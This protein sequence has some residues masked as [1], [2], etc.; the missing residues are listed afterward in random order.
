MQADSDDDAITANPTWSRR[1]PKAKAKVASAIKELLSKRPRK[2]TP[3]NV[4][5]SSPSAESL[6]EVKGP[7]THLKLFHKTFLGASKKEK[8]NLSSQKF[9]IQEKKN[10]TERLIGTL[11]PIQKM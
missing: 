8:E 10:G 5:Q 11:L 1:I 4:I 7:V 9:Y 6:T 2:P 3:K